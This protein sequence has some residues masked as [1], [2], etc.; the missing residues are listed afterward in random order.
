MIRCTPTPTYDGDE[1]QHTHADLGITIDRT[2]AA[3]RWQG[4][5]MDYELG[6]WVLCNQKRRACETTDV[7][8]ETS[9]EMSDAMSVE[10]SVDMS[11]NR[12]EEMSEPMSVEAGMF[13]AMCEA[14]LAN[15]SEET[16]EA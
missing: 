10:T 4:E 7:S 13:D 9:A 5:S 2:T 1:L 14:M 16:S 11:P 15:M 8:A 6:V 3:T 12:P